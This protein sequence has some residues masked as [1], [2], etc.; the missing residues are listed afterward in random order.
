LYTEADET[1]YVYTLGDLIAPSA[2]YP[3]DTYCYTGLISDNRLYLGGEEMLQIFEVTPSLTE[4][5]RLVTQIPTLQW[6]NKILRVG[7]DLLLG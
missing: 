3:V 2:T 5:L 7:D 1:L 4:P 6:V